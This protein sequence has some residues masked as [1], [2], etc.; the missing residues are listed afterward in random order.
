MARER[1]TG[2]TL[3]ELL[4]AM[5]VIGI[6]A[7]ISIPS[8]V[9]QKRKAAETSAKSDAKNIG[10]EIVGY[11]I[12]GRGTL[13]LRPGANPLTWELTNATGSVASGRLTKGNAVGTRGSITS[14]DSYCVSVSPS[15]PSAGA[16]QASNNGLSRGSC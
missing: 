2:F 10:Q 11:Y 6:L 1:E 7:A 12:D 9:L 14:D 13:S 15:E 4:V 5:M 3:V 8:F 16:W